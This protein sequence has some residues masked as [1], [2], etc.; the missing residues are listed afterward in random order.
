MSGARSARYRS[1]SSRLTPKDIQ[2][3]LRSGATVEEVAA[4]AGVGGE[5]V[6]RWAGPILA[7]QQAALG[8]AM[9]LTY[10]APRRGPSELPLG[11]AVA[12]NL[13]TRGV[14]LGEEEQAAGW[15]AYRHEGNQWVVS[16][17]YVF[18]RR[19]VNA[20]WLADLTEGTVVP[21]NR[22]GASLGFAAP[23]GTDPQGGDA[24]EASGEE[25]APPPAA[26]RRA[27]RSGAQRDREGDRQ[28]GLPGVDD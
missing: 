25:A 28:L 10:Q 5:W 21:T 19:P 4:E 15:S 17:R 7:E 11:E 13:V 27:A 8:R 26:G 20:Q 24:V 14:K 23:A 3:R 18:H 1:V 9:Q 2:A 6:E 12:R 22:M 16:F